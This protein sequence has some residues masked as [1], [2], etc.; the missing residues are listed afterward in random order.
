LGCCVQPST[1]DAEPVD[2][3]RWG[4]EP[5]VPLLVCPGTPF[6]YAPEHDWVLA[7]ICRRLGNCRLLFFEYRTRALSS[8]LR[9]RLAAEFT[10]RGLDFGRYVTF[11]LW[12]D[13]AGFQGLLRR[14]DAFLDTIG[15]SGF[16]TA[17][18]AVECELPIVTREGRFLRGRLASG[19][20]KRMDMADL[21]CADGE[22]Y[23][24][25]AVRL[26]QDADYRAQIRTRMAAG[27]D[28]LFNDREPIRALEEFLA[29]G[30]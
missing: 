28:A 3:M 14:A 24:A 21:V 7:E 16:N 17:L 9:N 2:A 25:L 12:Q 5:G 8:T 23:V 26:A 4:I 20:L 18:Q 29:Q 30:A 22:Q 27:R 1:L 13:R 19:I 10:R 15:F 11:L 6:K